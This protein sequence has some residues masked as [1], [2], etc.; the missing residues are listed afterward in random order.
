MIAIVIVA[1]ICAVGFIAFMHKK[2]IESELEDV[3]GRIDDMEE[4]VNVGVIA[5]Q[6]AAKNAQG[7]ASNALSSSQRAESKFAKH[8]EESTIKTTE[9][10]NA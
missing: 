5:A 4:D 2:W 8:I 1:V 10:K 9:E 3:H 7:I 6:Q